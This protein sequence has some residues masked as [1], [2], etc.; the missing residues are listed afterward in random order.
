MLYNPDWNINT[1]DP[2]IDSTLQDLINWLRLQ[3]P[4]EKYNFSDS[5][6]CLLCSF[7]KDQGVLN[8]VV[9]KTYWVRASGLTPHN[10]P[11][12]FNYIAEGSIFPS[13]FKSST[14]K[15]TYG[16]ALKRAEAQL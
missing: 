7:L 15:W 1:P 10:L 13:I 11:P 12:N 5:E 6:N 14:T 16:E 2:L 9:N 8:P 3:P 4:E